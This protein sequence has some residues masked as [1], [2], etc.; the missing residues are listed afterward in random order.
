MQWADNGIILGARSLGENKA[1]INIFTE[2]NGK[3]SG[4][5]RVNKSNKAHVQPGNKVAVTWYSRLPD[6]LGSW[7]IEPVAINCSSIM[8]DQSRLCALQS[9]CNIL[10]YCL[11][12]RE[13]HNNLYSEFEIYIGHLVASKNWAK[14]HILF[15]LAIL[16][17]LGYGLDFSCCAATGVVENLTY[18]S[19]RTGRAVSEAAAAPYIS[20]LLKLPQFL[21]GSQG[22]HIL[23]GLNL[24][25]YF[26]E[27]NLLAHARKP[28]PDERLRL[29]KFWAS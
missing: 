18:V 25:R 6:Q 8:T 20:Q 27:K 24:T 10:T 15:E 23:D 1:I 22:G 9:S 19:P 2:N 29:E 4:V 7:T 14:Q 16:S 26:I 17:E 11:A 21:V 5:L 13:A 3:Q 28:I 12:D